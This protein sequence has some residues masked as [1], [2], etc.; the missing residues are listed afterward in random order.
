ML[1]AGVAGGGAAQTSPYAEELIAYQGN[2]RIYLIGADGSGRRPL[3]SGASDLGLAWSPDGR[4]LAFTAGKERESFGKT[5]IRIAAADGSGV[6][7]LT[8]GPSHTASNPTWSPDGKRIAFDAWNYREERDSIYVINADGT[9]LRQL[10]RSGENVW[11]DWSP[12]GRW[13]A[14][15]RYI[16]TKAGDYTSTAALMAIHA[17]GT[18]LHRIAKFI[19]GQQCIC[20]DWS[21]DSTKIA[22]QASTSLTTKNLSEIFVMNAD[23]SGRRQLTHNRSRDENP[24][25]SADGTRLA[26]YSERVGNAEIYVIGAD[27]KGVRRLTRDPWYSSLPRWRTSG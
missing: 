25:W 27:G 22:Y 15:D 14:F 9:G 12:D 21:P 17:D 2:G 5:E 13:I 8:R 4:Q 16:Y 20:A 1:V 11:L 26:F 10:T 6:R 19:V 3:V 7:L 18:G 23:G 24:D